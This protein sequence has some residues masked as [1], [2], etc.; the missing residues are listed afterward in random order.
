MHE[1]FFD[2]RKFSLYFLVNLINEGTENKK[3]TQNFS[4][5]CYYCFSNMISLPII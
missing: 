2:S 3:E 4:K 1:K 5:K